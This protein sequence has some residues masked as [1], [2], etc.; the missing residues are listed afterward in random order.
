[1]KE[2]IFRGVI[3][4]AVAGAAAYF[5]ELALPVAVLFLVMVADYTSGTVRAWTRG[6]LWSRVGIM[7]IVKKAAYLLAVV[8]A[9]VADWVVQTAAGQ[10][11]VDF[12]GFFFFGLLVTIW[13]VLNE[14][15]SI[16][17]NISQIG[18]PLPSFLVALIEKLKS[19][20]ENKG[21]EL[22]K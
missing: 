12:G 20:T 2:N 18:V 22:L 6:G 7:G 15:I 16:L 4:A 3:A 19:T 8:V 10:I 11:G 5:Q 17:E 21:E 1:M 14:C 9:I 13:L